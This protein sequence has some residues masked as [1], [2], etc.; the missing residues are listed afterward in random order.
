VVEI[1]RNKDGNKI[2]LE[3]MERLDGSDL[4]DRLYGILIQV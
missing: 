1:F 2:L 3:V 4:W